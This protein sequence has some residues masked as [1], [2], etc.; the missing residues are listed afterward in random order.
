MK[1]ID[2]RTVPASVDVIAPSQPQP[3]SIFMLLKTTSTWL[4]LSPDQRF[5]F[6]ETDI[7]PILKAHPEVKMRFFDT[8]GFNSRVT[9]VMIWET[10][11]LSAYQAVVEALRE[12]DFWDTY[13]EIVEILPG[14]ENGYA[15][16]YEVDPL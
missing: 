7:R 11:D 15:N 10:E 5:A 1:T 2:A 9:D 6:L 14:I 3:Y 13:F 12:S 8:E 16:H 4:S